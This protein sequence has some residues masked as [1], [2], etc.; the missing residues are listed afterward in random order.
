MFSFSV[1]TFHP[2]AELG[3]NPLES[4]VS[5]DDRTLTAAQDGAPTQGFFPTVAVTMENSL[6]ALTVKPETQTFVPFIP[7][8]LPRP[9]SAGGEENPPAA[10]VESTEEAG[11]DG[12]GVVPPVTMPE[13]VT[14]QEEEAE[15]ERTGIPQTEAE[16]EMSEGKTASAICMCSNL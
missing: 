16:E 14:E 12:G 7:D 15:P 5:E 4:V 13:T 10:A 6:G 9:T 1:T 8:I 2:V 3:T 11:E